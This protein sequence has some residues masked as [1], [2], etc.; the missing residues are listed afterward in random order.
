MSPEVPV[1]DSD[2]PDSVSTTWGAGS[3]AT[4][5][6]KSDPES[7][8]AV[9]WKKH[10]LVFW[11]ALGGVF[12]FSGWIIESQGAV[13]AGHILFA[14]G[15]LSGGWMA[16]KESF[17]G[18]REYRLDV[19]V[20]MTLAAI[21]AAII[22]RWAEGGMLIF[23]FSLSNT[24]EHYALERTKDAVR[25][26]MDLRPA[27]AR[28]IVSDS[29][30]QVPVEELKVGDQI[31]IKPGEKIPADGMIIDGESTLD[32]STFTGESVP[33]DCGE[34]ES[35]LAGALNLTGQIVVRVTKRAADTALAAII[36]RVEQA[37]SGRVPTNTFVEWFGQRYT[38]GVLAGAT[39]LTILSPFVFG[40]EW[41][42]S[43][44]RSL[45]LLV[46]ASPCALIIS[47]PAAVLSAI[48]RGARKGVLFKGGR[49]LLALGSVR[50]VAFDKT[51]TLTQARAA[52]TDVIPLNGTSSGVLVALAGSI[53]TGSTHPLAQAIVAE[54]HRIGVAIPRVAD[55]STISGQGASGTVT[56]DGVTSRVLVGNRRFLAAND[57]ATTPEAERLLRSFENEGK[58]AILVGSDRLLGIIAL[59]DPPRHSAADIARLLH[60]VGVKSIG[61]LTGDNQR[62][63]DAMAKRLGIDQ[64]RAELLPEQKADVVAE[65]M[66]THESVVVVGDGV[67]DAPA[68]ASAT[69]G[70]AMGGA[71]NDVVLETADVVLMGDDLSRLHYGIRLSQATRRIII[72]NISFALIVIA[73]L[74]TGTFIGEIPLTIG[75][76]G[77]E[78]STLLVVMNSL[79]ML[80][81]E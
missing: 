46:V 69:I 25:S 62:V 36:H 41:R 5:S 10:H 44:Y 80:W 21:G 59:Q 79:R 58:T 50:A 49:H 42:A 23:L 61:I 45:T 73:I 6:P 7:N 34:S 32:R 9:L 76:I 14:L 56:L 78:G 48:G 28:L 26:L 19:N 81:F 31:L 40:T 1:I 66:R 18:L 30:R 43:F 13:L 63:A 17:D 72:Q 52:V 47:T 29:T 75:V 22:G 55:A 20:L 37:Q 15:Y 35:V 57:L 67:N 11:T 65:L 2:R 3:D 4:R 24:L 54:A 77:H 8:L 39:L 51:G 38:I 64:V 27:E 71:K 33:I 53:E 60:S 12:I 16:A 70:V 74:L 68:L